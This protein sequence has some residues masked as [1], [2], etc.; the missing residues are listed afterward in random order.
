MEVI[1]CCRS[2]RTTFDGHWHEY[3]T[4]GQALDPH[5]AACGSRDVLSITD[6]HWEEVSLNFKEEGTIQ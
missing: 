4:F 1:N 5:C 6:E 3:P 2:C